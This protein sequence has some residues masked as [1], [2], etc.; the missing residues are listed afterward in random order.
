MICPRLPSRPFATAALPLLL[1]ATLFVAG[2]QRSTSEPLRVIVQAGDLASARATVA[3]V[4]GVVTHELDIIDAVGARLT[5]SQMRRLERDPTLRLWADRQVRSDS[6]SELHDAP[7][8][9]GQQP[10]GLAPKSHYPTHVNAA[11][12]HARGVTGRGVTVAVVDSGYLLT[13]G[14]AR[15]VDGHQRLLAEY[16]A[17]SGVLEEPAGEPRRRRSDPYGHGSHVSSVL[18]SSRRSLD[19]SY[20]GV[21]PGVDLVIVSAFDESGVGT[22]LD[23]IRGLD[24]LLGNASRYGVRVVNL[25]L[26]AKPMSHYWDDPLNQAV[27]RLWDAGLVVV[28]SA[29]NTG[30]EPLSIT[31]PGNN[32]YVLTVGAISDNFTPYRTRDDFVTAFSAAGPTF[33]GFVKPEVV[34]P[35]GHML[36]LMWPRAAIAAAHPEHRLWGEY[37]VMSGTS[38][39]TAV[40]SGIAALLLELEPGLSPDDVKCRLVATAR[41]AMRPDGSA[42]Y[43]VFQQGAG[44]VDALA[45]SRSVDSEC[46]NGGLDVRM[47][48]ADKKHY[49]GP[50][51]VDEAGTYHVTDTSDEGTAWNGVYVRHQSFLWSNTS[52]DASSYLWGNGET[53]VDAYL[54][55]NEGDTQYIFSAGLSEPVVPN[56][57]VN[58]Q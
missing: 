35:G 24:W 55:S 30:P 12:L 57:W 28:A 31:V 48:L 22:Y 5:A 7:K 16:D 10:G 45:A 29:G 41:P 52:L 25:S 4:G 21:A 58:Q 39:A 38:Q 33:E 43:S 36:G 17:R 8:V 6:R 9:F 54:W 34:A 42:A 20:N 2:P 13:A 32:P 26:S 53:F 14:I 23:V 46:A 3:R 37:F 18:S 51:N 44:L 49:G 50:A 19:G 1:L 40:V 15:A 47:D 27:M 11:D 56:I